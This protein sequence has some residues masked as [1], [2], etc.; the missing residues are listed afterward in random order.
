MHG[1]EAIMKRAREEGRLNP[2]VMSS[3]G[4][5]ETSHEVD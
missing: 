2:S 3:L 1:A 5:G 4:V